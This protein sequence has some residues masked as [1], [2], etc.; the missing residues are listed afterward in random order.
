MEMLENLRAGLIGERPV[1]NL[2]EE[3]REVLI[4][5]NA[6]KA[7]S[8]W[9]F[10]FHEVWPIEELKTSGSEKVARWVEHRLA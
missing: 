7:A 3:I 10:D 1:V 6:E 4:S 5:R 9:G 8:L 2:L